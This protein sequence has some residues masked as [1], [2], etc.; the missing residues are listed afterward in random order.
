AVLRLYLGDRKG[1]DQI[2]TRMLERFERSLD[3]TVAYLIADTCTVGPN[4]VADTTRLVELAERAAASERSPWRLNAVGVVHYRAGNYE[5]AIK[6]I[7]DSVAVAPDWSKSWNYAYLGMAHNRLGQAELA[8]EELKEAGQALDKMLEL[9][10]SA[11]ALAM[12]WP[13]P[14]WHV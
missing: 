6:D 4:P 11:G 13:K 8:R 2:C 12:W 14:W 3:D 9:K 7:Q 1:Y 10:L 5:K